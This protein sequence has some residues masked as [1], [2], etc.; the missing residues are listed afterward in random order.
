LTPWVHLLYAWMALKQRSADLYFQRMG[1]K[2]PE[3]PVDVWMHAA[4]VGEINA[5]LPLI[6]QF[7]AAHPQFSV[8]VSCNTPTGFAQLQKHLDQDTRSFYLPVD[9][10]CHMRRL[11]SRVRPRCFVIMETEIWPNL[12]RQ[13]YRQSIKLLIINARISNKTL[14]APR[15]IRGLYQDCLRY[16]SAILARSPTDRQRFIDMGA[17]AERCKMIGNIKFHIADLNDQT[18]PPMKLDRPYIL[19]ASTH[20][21]EELQLCRALL[22]LDGLP[23]LV[24]APRHPQRAAKIVRDLEGLNCHVAQRSLGHRITPQTRVYLA[25]TLGELRDFIRHAEF[26]IMGGSFIPLGGHNILEVAAAKKAT[27]CGPYMQQFADET[28]LLLQVDALRQCADIKDVVDLVKRWLIQPDLAKEV[29][30]S[31][32]TCMLAQQHILED[33]HNAIYSFVAES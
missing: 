27:I 25:D 33:Y 2:F 30:L 4:S 11:F 8:L 28:R 17:D 24:I 14:N 23:L 12:Y 32:Y 19:L 22:A 10:E 31:A 15:W 18:T 3:R 5:L 1:F 29:G 13:L 26:V 7:R 6:R 16:C 20:D 21:D 9:K